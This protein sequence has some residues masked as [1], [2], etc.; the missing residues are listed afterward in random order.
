MTKTEP[1]KRK[2]LKYILKNKSEIPKLAQHLKMSMILDSYYLYSV[3]LK[4]ISHVKNIFI[5]GTERKENFDKEC[6]N[7]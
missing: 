7:Y 4:G 3:T 5:F 1:I 6:R 2:Y